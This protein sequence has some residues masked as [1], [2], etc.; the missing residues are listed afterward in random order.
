[1]RLLGIVALLGVMVVIGCGG[2]SDHDNARVMGVV[3]D[4][5]G[6]PA[7]D[8]IIT[9]LPDDYNPLRDSAYVT[10][11]KAVTTSLGSFS[12]DM[13]PHGTYTLT[14][15]DHLRGLGFIRKGVRISGDRVS[16]DTLKVMQR[17][18]L[19]LAYDSLG[20]RKGSAVYVPG[21]P[22][23]HIVED[24]PS[25]EL[26]PG[27]VV[28]KGYDR[29][30]DMDIV[31]LKTSDSIEVAP[32]SSYWLGYSIDAPYHLSASD[33]ILTELVGSV[34]EEYRFTAEVPVKSVNK[35]SMYRFSWG[36]GEI[37]EWSENCVGNHAWDKP[38]VYE[39]QY[40]LMYQWNY[41]AW[42]SPITIYIE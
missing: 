9:L 37:S 22:F 42:S 23:F 7:E 32:A 18:V 25:M 29:E 20:L 19:S 26:F 40:Q 36:D 24:D 39:V 35:E 13:I 2:S 8:V 4:Y 3:A 28:L 33:E 12:L 31:L 16:L 17:S 27:T 6:D 10:E 21:T 11:E 1:M 14:A 41:Q 38:G 34:G 15:V 30:Q 5:R